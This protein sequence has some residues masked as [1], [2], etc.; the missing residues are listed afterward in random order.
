LIA[1]GSSTGARAGGCG[2]LGCAV[3][4]AY[5][6]PGRSSSDEESPGPSTWGMRGATAGAALTG[7]GACDAAVA[8]RG[9]GG[10]MT[11]APPRAPGSDG[12]GSVGSAYPA[13]PGRTGNRASTGSAFTPGTDGP[14]RCGG[15]STGTCNAPTAAWC[16]AADAAAAMR[17][18]KAYACAACGSRCCSEYVGSGRG[19]SNSATF[20][21]TTLACHRCVHSSQCV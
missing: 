12:P 19:T 20:D 3:R 17:G 16:A 2:K 6:G 15:A 21:A 9:G 18:S 11:C 1:S 10:N 5:A 7:G 14:A 8:A 13:R 4:G